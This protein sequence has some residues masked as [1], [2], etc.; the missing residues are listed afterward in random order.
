[1]GVD[2][3]KLV[4]A[5]KGK[6]PVLVETNTIK[7]AIREAGQLAADGDVVLLS[8]ACASFDLFKITWIAAISLK[9]S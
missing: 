9:Q 2:N 1:M 6:V 5:F 4:E 7:D 8:P 3:T